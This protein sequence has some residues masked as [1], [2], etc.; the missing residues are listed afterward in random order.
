MKS[1]D[2]CRYLDNKAYLFPPPVGEEP[3]E[4]EGFVTPFYCLRTQEP[5]GPDGD[6]VGEHCCVAKRGCYRPEVEL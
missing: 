1:P 4:S 5:V 6:D 2:A 3:Q